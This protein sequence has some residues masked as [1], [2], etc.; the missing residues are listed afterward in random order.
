MGK[1]ITIWASE[2][3][4]KLLKRLAEKQ[5]RSLSNFIK[6]KCGVLKKKK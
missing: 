2:E 3:E 6:T 5:N 4:E 1:P